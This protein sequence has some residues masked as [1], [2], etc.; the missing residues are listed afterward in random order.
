MKGDKSPSLHEGKPTL[1][2]VELQMI[3]K[4]G[5]SP[6]EYFLGKNASWQSDMRSSMFYYAPHQLAEEEKRIHDEMDKKKKMINLLRVI[7]NSYMLR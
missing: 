3:E 6:L 7:I 1:L 2:F 4:F 5:I